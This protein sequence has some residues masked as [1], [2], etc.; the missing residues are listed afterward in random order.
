MIQLPIAVLK[1]CPCVRVSLRSMQVPGG[2]DGRSAFDVKTSHVFPQCVLA[3]I[4]L[5]GTE[6]GY[7]V[8]RARDRCKLGLLPCSFVV[9]S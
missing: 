4:S 6:A 3:T 2:F 5:V 1:G 9:M 8:V 7:G